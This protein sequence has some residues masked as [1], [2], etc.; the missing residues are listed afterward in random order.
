MYLYIYSYHFIYTHR[1]H[2]CIHTYH[3]VALMEKKPE[4]QKKSKW[5]L[6]KIKNFCP[7]KDTMKYVKSQPT[8]W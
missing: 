8:E 3:M 1:T 2:M 5:E 4:Q 7:S 6:I